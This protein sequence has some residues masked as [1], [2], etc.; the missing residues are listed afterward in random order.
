MAKSLVTRKK[1]T[2]PEVDPAAEASGSVPGP[3]PAFVRYIGPAGMM[4]IENRTPETG[5][6]IQVYPHHKEHLLKECAELFE[7][8]DQPAGVDACCLGCTTGGACAAMA[9]EEK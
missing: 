5:A 6:V 3:A 8:A 4:R 2:E 1:S 7:H 9:S